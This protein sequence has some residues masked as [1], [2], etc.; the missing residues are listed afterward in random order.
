MTLV[1]TTERSCLLQL[2]QSF[3]IYSFSPLFGQSDHQNRFCTQKHNPSFWPTPRLHVQCFPWSTGTP[4]RRRLLWSFPKKSR[5]SREVEKKI[6][7]PSEGQQCRETDDPFPYKDSLPTSQT[8]Q[9]W[10]RRN[11]VP[12]N[13]VRKIHLGPLCTQLWQQELRGHVEQGL[14][15]DY[16]TFFFSF[17]FTLRR[18]NITLK[19]TIITVVWTD[20]R[21][22]KK[23]LSTTMQMMLE[24]PKRDQPKKKVKQLAH[25][26]AEGSAHRLNRPKYP[27]RISRRIHTRELKVGD[28][29]PLR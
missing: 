25:P 20:D 15:G 22:S 28:F 14:R 29:F 26:T 7:P 4:S 19:V 2:E 18:K 10:P 11:T 8:D 17:G 23:N 12:R 1:S 3:K 27:T 16:D 24:N 21:T 9:P 5:C 6:Q 13:P